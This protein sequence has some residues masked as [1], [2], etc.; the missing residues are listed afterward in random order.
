MIREAFEAAREDGA[1]STEEIPPIEVEI[2]AKEE[3]GDYSTNLGMLL[4]K[5]ERKAPFVIAESLM[6]FL[7]DSGGALDEVL[8]A[9]PVDV[10]GP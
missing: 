1:L 3:F 7:P 10:A 5:T 9:V 2:P 4:A 6:K 8:I